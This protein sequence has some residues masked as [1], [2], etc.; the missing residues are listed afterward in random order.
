[1]NGQPER[2]SA[3]PGAPDVLPARPRR[4]G[5]RLRLLVRGG[6][7]AGS[8]GAIL[9]ATAMVR[10][11]IRFPDP[12]ALRQREQ[13]PIVRILAR[14]GTLLA[15]RGSAGKPVPL[16]ELPPHVVHAVVAIEDRRFFSH[17]G[18]DFRGLARAMLANL[19]AARYAQGGSTLTQQ[20]AKN[21]FLTSERTVERK[22]EEVILAL[23]LELRLGKPGILELYLNRVYF[24]AGVYGIEAAAQRYF[25]KSARALSVPEAAIIAGLLK[26]PSRL[27]PA[28]RP[29]LAA[30][31][32]VIVLASMRDEGFITEAGYEEA[33]H[34]EVTY[35]AIDPPREETG[36]EF[37]V[38]YIFDRLPPLAGHGQSAITIETTIDADLQRQAQAALAR[39]LA[40]AN[41]ASDTTEGAIVVIDHEGGVRAMVGGRAWSRSQFNRAVR[42]RR[43]PGSAFKPVLYLAALE[44]GKTP[45]TVVHDRPITIGGWSPKNDSG[46]YAGTMTLRQALAHSVNTVAVALQQ[47]IGSARVVAVARRLG[48][49]STLRADASLALGTSEVTLLELTGAYGT[50]AN[51][52]TSISPH[53]VRRVRTDRGIVL[54]ARGNSAPTMAAPAVH[55]ANIN[56]MLHTA[57]VAGTG[58]R[59]AFPGHTAA[60]KTGT[61]QDNRDAWFVGFTGHLTAGVWVGND[62]NSPMRGIS[63]GG[64]PALIW[65]DVMVAAHRGLGPAPIVGV[66][67]A[68]PPAATPV[69]STPPAMQTA[70]RRPLGPIDPALFATQKDAPAL[71]KQRLEALL[72]SN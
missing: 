37:A 12:S 72:T 39:R 59:A 44:A 23:W 66:N 13:A 57:L 41:A 9:F 19:R 61:T 4:R 70:A 29:E 25:G 1:M 36:L 26:A 46:T 2:G 33:L 67:E 49:T 24:G 10:Y 30:S 17:I 34:Q 56:S 71:D 20:L 7:L 5:W 38:D 65:R 55:V 42:A 27:S 35:A 69:A 68:A 43:Q 64:L 52:G 18:L 51:G 16:A 54:H 53:V 15:E 45:D 50:L 28:S 48:I 14:D 60:G 3:A 32:A 22:I 40:S 62:D 47:D 58:R 11:T 31:R 63:G 8:L 21:L 6:T